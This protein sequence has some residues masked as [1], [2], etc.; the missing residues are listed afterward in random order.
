MVYRDVGGLDADDDYFDEL[1]VR[2]AT[3]KSKKRRKSSSR[4]S[5]R[6]NR[7]ASSNRRKVSFVTKDGR[8]VS[9][10]PK[11]TKSRRKS[12]R[13]GGGKRPYPYWLKKYMFKKRR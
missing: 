6:K 10:T 8:K 1:M 11:H 3:R 9:F 12:F 5:R 2:S 7:R 4:A 13:R